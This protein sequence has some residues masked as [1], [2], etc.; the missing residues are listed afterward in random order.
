MYVSDVVGNR[1]VDVVYS[2]LL[3]LRTVDTDPRENQG[4]AIIYPLGMKRLRALE[5]LKALITTKV[6][7]AEM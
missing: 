7:L 5:F 6:K 1:F 4:G 2:I 3:V